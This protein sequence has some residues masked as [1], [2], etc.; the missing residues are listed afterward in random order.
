MIVFI[1][2]YFLCKI[3]FESRPD[4]LPQV[5]GLAI[6]SG[7]GMILKGGKESEKTNL[8]MM[9]IIENCVRKVFFSKLFFLYS[10]QLIID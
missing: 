6:K 7:N 3:I 1:L 2:V 9:E 8:K 4:V 5:L 10:S